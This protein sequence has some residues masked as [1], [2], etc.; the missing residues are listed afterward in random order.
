MCKITTG[1]DPVDSS[2]II[3]EL[4]PVTDCENKG[5]STLNWVQYIEKCYYSNHL[6]GLGNRLNH[7]VTIMEAI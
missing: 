3:N 5:N 2:I 4:F 7:F 1:V 6:M